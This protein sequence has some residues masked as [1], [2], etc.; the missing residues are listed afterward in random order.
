MDTVTGQCNHILGMAI[1]NFPELGETDRL[2]YA[3]NH[4]EFEGEEFKFCPLC[5]QS[6]GEFLKRN[7]LENLIH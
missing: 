3:E 7:E 1:C 6:L 5:G 2:I 4:I